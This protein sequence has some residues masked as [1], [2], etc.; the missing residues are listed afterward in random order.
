MDE[1]RGTGDVGVAET[2]CDCSPIPLEEATVVV[3][4][5]G[6]ADPV[7]VSAV[8]EGGSGERLEDVSSEGAADGDDAP[9]AGVVSVAVATV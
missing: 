7:T 4:L 3:V 2:C 8:L 9:S 1:A 6:F 5:C